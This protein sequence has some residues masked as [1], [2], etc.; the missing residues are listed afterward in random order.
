MEKEKKKLPKK[1]RIENGIRRARKIA[2][3]VAVVIAVIL[4]IKGRKGNP[5]NA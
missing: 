2:A 4:K 3:T 1:E 5:N